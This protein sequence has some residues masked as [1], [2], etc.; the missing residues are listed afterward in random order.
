MTFINF[1]G[2]PSP[3]TR[4][5]KFSSAQL[6]MGQSNGSEDTISISY[7]ES[8]LGSEYNVSLPH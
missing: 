1:D 8:A 6:G 2:M 4:R 5:I 7:S 3:I